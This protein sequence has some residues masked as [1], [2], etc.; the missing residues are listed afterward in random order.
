MRIAHLSNRPGTELVTKAFFFPQFEE[1]HVDANNEIVRRSRRWFALNYHLTP[2]TVSHIAYASRWVSTDHSVPSRTSRRRFLVTRRL[3]TPIRVHVRSAPDTESGISIG[4][5]NCCC[6]G[7]T[8]YQQANQKNSGILFH[9][10]YPLIPVIGIS[11][12]QPI[13]YDTADRRYRRPP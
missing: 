8:C 2:E 1:N 11:T 3:A 12:H 9:V 13:Q 4:K 10:E 6:T 5:V 7:T